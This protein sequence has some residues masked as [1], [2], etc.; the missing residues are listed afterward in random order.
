MRTLIYLLFFLMVCPVF[1]QE[2]DTSYK[3]R[4]L[5]TSEIDLL[6]SFYDQDGQNAA[7]TGGEGTEQLTDLTSS[8]V[9]RIPMNADDILTLD[10]GISAYTSASTSNVN[11]LDGN[12]NTPVSPFI[13]S[14]GASRKDQLVHFRPSYQHSS[15]DR[16]SIWTA[17][18]YFSAEYDYFSLGFGGG[19]TRLFNEKNTEVSASAQVYLDQWN[20]RYPIELREGFFDDRIVG[21]G[22]YAPIFN[23]FDN[24]N[25][26]SYSLSLGV[27]Q[28]LSKKLQGALFADLVLQRGLLSTPFQRVYFGDVDDFFIDAFQLADD[29]ERLPD[30]RLKIPI[31][32]RLNY[33]L[34]DTFIIRSYYRFYADDWGIRSHT[35]SLEVPVKLGDAF[36]LYP[37]YRFYTQ[38]AADY[39]NEKEAALSTFDFYTSDYDLSQYTAHQYGMGV[40]YKDIFTKAKVFHFGLKSLDLRFNAYDRSDGLHSF[41]VTLGTTFVGN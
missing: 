14:S 17:N 22:T 23:E 20:P 1:A 16:N 36:T 4:I 21:N 15:E 12:A 9:V 29:I 33:Y 40:R 7:V 34:N 38:T 28:I 35:A 19:Y 25:R 24:V 32:G 26:N 8:I 31:G 11:P 10:I 3:K 30:T 6:F 39:F 5:E 27:S 18:A 2:G 13:A 37:N 41:I